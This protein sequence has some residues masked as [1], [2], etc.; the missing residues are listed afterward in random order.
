[1]PA[2]LAPGTSSVIEV[3]AVIG[4]GGGMG[5]VYRA[6]DARLGRQVAIKVLRAEFAS[7]PERLARFEQEARAAAALNHPHIAA[8]FDIGTEAS[9]AL[10]RPGVPRGRFAPHAAFRAA[11]PH[12]DRLGAR[13]GGCCQRARGRPPRGLVHRDVKPE[14]VMVS[15]DGH[16]KVLDFGLAKLTKP[17]AVFATDANSPTGLG[18]MGGVVMG[19]VGYLAPEQAA[20]Q[21][22]DQR[23]DIFSLGCILDQM[24]ASERPFAGRSAAETIARVLQD[25]PRPLSDLRPGAP[26]EFQRIV[27]KCLAKDPARRYQHADDLA[28]DLRDFVERPASPP[29]LPSASA[30]HVARGSRWAWPALAVVLS[31]V[32]AWGWFRTPAVVPERPPSRLAVIMPNLGGASTSLQR[33]IAIYAGRQHAALRRDHRGHRDPHHAPAARRDRPLRGARRRAI[34]G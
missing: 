29:V 25:D 2:P 3:V 14:N 10:H 15:P 9:H 12:A 5:E 1:M 4:A 13:G 31:A 27:G 18:T 16:A 23:A 34:P 33:Q 32:A 8:V 11:E 30:R 26:L 17:D 20:G 28:L 21:P 7:D 19:T 22:A 6:V 24:A